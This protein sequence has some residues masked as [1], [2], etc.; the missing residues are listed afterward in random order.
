MGLRCK[1]TWS[2]LKRYNDITVTKT[3]HVSSSLIALEISC[4]RNYLK[5]EHK[6]KK[7]ARKKQFPEIFKLRRLGKTTDLKKADIENRKKKN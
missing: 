5:K 4:P 2:Y 6:T 3:E 1:S 7:D